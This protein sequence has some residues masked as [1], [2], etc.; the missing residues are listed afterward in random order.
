MLWGLK[1]RIYGSIPEE[2]VWNILWS[3]WYFDRIFKNTF[4]FPLSVAFYQ[5]STLIFVYMLLLPGGQKAEAC[6]PSNTALLRLLLL[7]GCDFS[8]VESGSRRFEEFTFLF[9]YSRSMRNAKAGTSQKRIPASWIAWL[10]KRH[11]L[12]GSALSDIQKHWISKCFHIG[13]TWLETIRCRF[14]KAGFL[15]LRLQNL[16]FCEL[17]FNT[18]LIRPV[19]M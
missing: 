7:Q 3:K 15:K 1:L 9:K 14:K 13:L 19:F 8:S 17:Q 18:R 16:Y 12:Q 5:C 11:K 2:F 10:W 4:I 6:E